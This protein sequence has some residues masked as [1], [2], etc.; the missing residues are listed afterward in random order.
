MPDPHRVF[1][2]SGHMIDAVDRP[3]PRFPPDK[4][5]IAAQAIASALDEL[6]AGAD[7]LG[8]T[9]G[10]CGG[11][12]LFAEAMLA[13]GAQLELRLP[14]DEETFVRGS[15]AFAKAPTVP[16]RWAER[17]RAA[18]TNPGTRVLVMPEVLG[19]LPAGEDPYARCN[20]WML[21]AGLAMGASRLV[22]VCLWDG[23]GGDGP[24]GTADM[25]RQVEG[26]GGTVRRLDTRAL[27]QTG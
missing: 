5:P 11:D 21:E 1:L 9:E 15:V 20:L 14:F 25:V 2:F 4:E 18:R 3:K 23:G 26:R 10:A 19:P 7:D 17:F 6:G 8:I 16:D 12:L 22:L 13:R 27:W 24:G